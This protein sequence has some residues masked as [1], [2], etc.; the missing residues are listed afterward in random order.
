[1]RFLTE[2]A[3]RWL[4]SG[5]AAV[6]ARNVPADGSRQSSSRR[7]L[8]E[9]LTA[10]H[11]APRR[12]LDLGC[13]S[14]GSHDLVAA[15]APLAAWVGVDI[16]DSPEV[17]TRTRRDLAFVTF[18]GMRLP[19]AA[20]AFDVVY[21]HQVF[22]HVRRP[23]ALLAEVARV[24]SPGGVF[25]GSTSQL[26]PFHSRSLWNYTAYGFVEL[27]RAA[28]F[29]GIEVQPGIDGLTLTGRR[30]FSFVKLG[31]PFDFFFERESP[32]NLAIELVARMVGLDPSARNVLKLVFAGQ[33]VFVAR[34]RELQYRAS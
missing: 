30:V 29:R 23:E 26:E 2:A 11:T 5:D 19:L 9:C 18:D 12:V 3:R 6:L 15:A 21:S 24:L 33:F 1:M 14:G 25:I 16:A 7:A 20:D 28:G 34:K 32:L 10:A 27:L 31:R 4:S 8:L 22:E 17:Q 13:G